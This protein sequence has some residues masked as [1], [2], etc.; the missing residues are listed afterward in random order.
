MV[1]SLAVVACLAPSVG[2]AQTPLG[3]NELAKAKSMLDLYRAQL[4]AEEYALLSSKLAQTEQAYVE[5]TTLT[6]VGAQAAAAEA[7]ASAAAATGGRALL[8]GVVEALPL[9]LLFWPSTAHAPGMKEE[10]PAVRAAKEKLAKSVEELNAATRRVV[11]ERAAAA[12][13]PQ[14]RPVVLADD[15]EC[16]LHGGQNSRR[17]VACIYKCDGVADHIKVKLPDEMGTCPGLDGPV[18]WRHI[19]RFPQYL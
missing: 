5:L 1:R 4:S 7:G 6:E 12:K 17:P 14:W 9:F 15:V 11:D 18:K 8:G 13:R 19:K 10:K 3:V 16:L 2:L